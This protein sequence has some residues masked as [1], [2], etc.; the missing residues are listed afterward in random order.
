MNKVNPGN[1]EQQMSDKQADEKDED[2]KVCVRQ[3]MQMHQV[4]RRYW[5][6]L[7]LP[8]TTQRAR[9]VI[10]RVTLRQLCYSQRATTERI[11]INPTPREY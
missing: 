7:L 3:A 1:T 2:V 6:K 5:V 8:L 4:D 10:N 9:T 11:Q